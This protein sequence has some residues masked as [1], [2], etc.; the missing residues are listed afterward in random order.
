MSSKLSTRII[1]IGSWLIFVA[2]WMSLLVLLI[3]RWKGTSVDLHYDLVG[4]LIFFGVLW[5]RL[6]PGRNS[7][8]ELLVTSSA[9][10]VVLD[11]VHRVI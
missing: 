8:Y 1:I 9:L 11:L 5:G 10:A 2:A 4:L 3:F 7:E 6:V